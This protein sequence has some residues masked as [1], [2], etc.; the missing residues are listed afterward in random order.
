MFSILSECS[1]TGNNVHTCT[2]LQDNSH[3]LKETVFVL[4]PQTTAVILSAAITNKPEAESEKNFT[5]ENFTT[6]MFTCWLWGMFLETTMS[7]N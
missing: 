2:N 7:W 1:L 6:E 5:T 3:C 4:I